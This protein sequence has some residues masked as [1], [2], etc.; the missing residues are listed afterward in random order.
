[1]QGSRSA[2]TVAGLSHAYGATP[3]LQ[4]IAFSLP[5]GQ[6]LALLGPSGCGKTT[7]LRLIAG[8]VE[9]Q[10]GRIDIAGDLVADAAGKRFLPPEARG[11]GMV[12]QDYALW[13]HLTVA[14]NVAFPLE[15]RGVPSAERKA[16]TQSA[17]DRV[18]LGAMANRSPSALSGG[19]QQRVAI[20]RA[21]VAEPKLVLFDEPL[22]NLDRE[23]RDQLAAE[24]GDLL[25]NLGLSGIYVTHDQAEAFAIA[26]QVA[27]MRAGR[28][29]QMSPPEEL[30]DRPADAGVAEFLQL[31][32]L[33]PA[34]IAEDGVRLDGV[35]KPLARAG[36]DL[37]KARPGQSGQILLPRRALTPVSADAGD[38][39]GHVIASVFRGDH[40]AVTLQ[41]DGPQ[42]QHRTATILFPAPGR[43]AIGER[44]GLAVDPDRLRF[45][46]ASS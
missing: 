26:D 32:T 44:I 16:R 6:V 45:F 37:A 41:A 15:M 2:V 1:M 3:V 46:P 14:G 43:I 8:L 11:L 29:A 28:I 27:V 24:I 22:S 12:F 18:G 34:R 20:A 42:G 39:V 25:H 30:Y 33:L 9:P 5:Q 21:I 38:L 31:G 10:S 36:D 35:D 4:D 19:Q 7:L 17:L 40:H 23:L 13:P